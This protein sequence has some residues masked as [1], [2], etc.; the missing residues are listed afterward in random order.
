MLVDITKQLNEG[1][2]MEVRE[3]VIASVD[4]HEWEEVYRLLYE[5][6][7]QIAGFEQNTTV[8]KQAIVIIADHLRHHVAVADPEI[9][10]SAC[11]VKLSGLVK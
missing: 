9:N 6:I 2:W 8:W 5:N 3:G 10:F 1:K 11:M 7:D 4:D